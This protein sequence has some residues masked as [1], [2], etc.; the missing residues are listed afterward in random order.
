MFPKKMKKVGAMFLAACVMLGS[1]QLPP[2]QT[3]AAAANLALTAVATASNSEKDNGIARIND[4]DM[5]TRWSHD[6]SASSWAQLTWD[7]AQTM[8]SFRINWEV[9]RTA[10]YSLQISNDGSVWQ[11]IWTRNGAPGSTT[12]EITLD[13]PVTSKY[14][15]LKMEGI[16]D[17]VWQAVSVYELE[18]Y[19][20]S[21]EDARSDVD[22]LVSGIT[23][24]QVAADGRSITMPE[25]P[26]GVSV[27]FCAD[28]EQVIGEDGTIYPPYED[29]VVKGFFEV[30]QGEEKAK[31]SEFTVNVAGI[32]P[33]EAG[34]NEKPSVIPELQEWHG[35]KGQFV[36]SASSKIVAAPELA[37]TA[38]IFAADYEDITGN[39]IEVVEGDLL[40]AAAG[41]FCLTLDTDDQGLGKE[42]YLLRIGNVAVV[43]A[44]EAT[45]AYWG[46][47]SI[48]QI[49][50]QTGGTIAKGI[51]RDYPKYEVRGFSLDVGRKPFSMDTVKQFAKN[52]SWYKLN[53]F[54]VHVS[55]D[56]I[57][58]EDY[59]NDSEDKSKD[60]VLNL[61]KENAYSG[62]RLESSLVNEETGVSLTSEDMYY[63]KD[64]F[65]SFIKDSRT[66][67][68][69]I[70]PEIDMPA[71]ALAITR[72][73]PEY[74]S[75]DW[76]SSTHR[77]IIDE[78]DL[79]NPESTELAKRIW[80]DYFE[81][82][83][84][85][86]DEE[87]TVHIGTDEFH[88][89]AGQEG[90]EMFRKFSDDMIKFV[91]GTG[92]KVRM[93]GSLSNKA[94]T[95]P[96]AVDGVQLNVWDK[97]YSV[98]KDMYDLGYD[99]INTLAAAGSG[100]LYVVPSGS[101]SKGGY[102]DYLDT[103]HLYNNWT[104][105]NFDGYEVMAGEDQML[106]GVYAVWHDNIDT[107]KNGISE[108]DSFD[109]FFD[110]LP[111]VSAKLWGVPEK[112]WS[113]F[114]EIEEK[115]GTAPNTNMYYEVDSVT[116]T[117]MNYTFDDTL[118]KD[119]SANGYD[120]TEQ[121][122][123]E[124]VAV[125]GGKALKLAG[126]E[127]YITTPV[128][129]V[130][131]N[132]SLTVKVKMDEDAQGEQIL[133]ES[134]E[135]FGG[136]GTYA[137]KASQK[138]TGKV[139]FSREGYDFSFDYTLPKG[140]WVELT[141]KGYQ[142]TAEL[143]V[144]GELEDTLTQEPTV[145]NA[146]VKWVNT[147]VMPVG[148]IGSKTN[149]FKGQIDYAVVGGAEWT[150]SDDLGKI[151]Q[152]EMTASACT[153]HSE[154]AASKAIDGDA[155]TIW[156]TDWGSNPK[157]LITDSHT[158]WF[159]LTLD[160]AKTINKLT[161]LPRITGTTGNITQ[162]RIEVEKADGTVVTDAVSGTWELDGTLKTVTF[163]PVEAK[164]ITIHILDAGADSA[165][166]HGSAAEFNLYQPVEVNA[167]MLNAELDALKDL[168]AADYTA[169]SWKA[170]TDVIA[171]I[172]AIAGNSGST[173]EE[174]LYAYGLAGKA[175]DVLA[176][177]PEAV[178]VDTS[179]LQ[180]KI[181]EL[182]NN[183]NSY[184]NESAAA[185]AEYL[186]NAKKLLVNPVTDTEVTMM[187]NT[188]ENAEDILVKKP[189][190]SAKLDG[191]VTD[192]E[193]LDLTGY[194]EDSVKIFKNALGE[195]KA[196][197][198]DKNATQEQV[199]AVLKK[200]NDAIAGLKK[201][202]ASKPE[203]N[204]KP[205]PIPEPEPIPSLEPLPAVGKAVVL[206]GLQYTVTKS[207]AKQGTVAVTKQ[208]NKTKKKVTI[209]ATI[210]ANGYTFKVTSIS[211]NV[212]QKNKKLTTVVI[213]SN[214]T[215]IAKKS[216]YKCSKLKNITFKGKK[217]PKIARQ[218]FK[219]IQ[220]KAKITVPKKMKQKQFNTL[221][222]R[223]KSAGVGS[224]ATYKKK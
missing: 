93:W 163:D 76:I 136:F 118:T 72:V 44:A 128:N 50:K 120:A 168:N 181:T 98:P 187:L 194:T 89:A 174:K 60:A 155:S 70:V 201:A 211:K 167:D 45:G 91:Q 190:E 95:T 80:N 79:T 39:P 92:R 171:K 4:G 105:N 150:A 106:G 119:A 112:S 57:F 97:G 157:D 186:V 210:E 99:M 177:I 107:R 215:N 26:E 162:Y 58:M 159:K 148:R 218:T 216:F 66:I 130:G 132:N 199:D 41:D 191:A 63:T 94:G 55:D 165:G 184:T 204:P 142:N 200:L 22:K 82:D 69:D 196:V 23:A 124:Q 28:Y 24:P 113:E 48:L 173:D 131:P 137:V 65:R 16:T 144:N 47:V 101:G 78:L 54:Q 111:T 133:C 209:P 217:A 179:A 84:P 2:L 32:Y 222:K 85:V 164:S 114:T 83:D 31:T 212:F 59:Y 135:E 34:A 188:L 145:K 37:K 221:K 156:H 51:A 176:E 125:D 183:M 206:N 96:V 175:R 178:T 143:Y 203:P 20:T 49:L 146:G 46:T 214:V 141:I 19:A 17:S 5:S 30:T 202:T 122:N 223:M 75:W 68:V 87:T 21:L 161:Y 8:K 129:K 219:G 189:T 13:E 1:V 104:V 170:F 195:A 102:A 110:A 73:F 208:I 77:P 117:V 3:K 180:A 9:A 153:Q 18:V 205:E 126:G 103:Q 29:K 140:Q 213:G 36:P 224:K 10:N 15:R 33:Q 166:K 134:W 11:N 64:E 151:D 123:A 43:E 61:T 121:K 149:S 53:S 109:R 138:E 7:T 207:D 152:S 56:L 116:S 147:L 88:G 197:L 154:G 74:M 127:S 14:L 182:E 115:T 52:M 35:G 71:H 169:Q 27:R 12:D 40:D 90:K 220:A 86:F 158:H 172:E 62:F 6:E 67:G 192:A 25:V 185:F 38:A 108:Y 100:S 42:G 198:A 193:K 160:T 139:G 81:G